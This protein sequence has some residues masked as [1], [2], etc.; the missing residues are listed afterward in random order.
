MRNNII[1]VNFTAA[2]K[3]RAKF[4]KFFSLLLNKIKNLFYY[5]DRHN[6]KPQYNNNYNKSTM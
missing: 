1:K 2:Q 5:K 6:K 4:K 3:R